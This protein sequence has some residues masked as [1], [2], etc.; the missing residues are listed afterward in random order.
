MYY[1]RWQAIDE[2][3]NRNSNI[4]DIAGPYETREDAHRGLTATLAGGRYGLCKL[5]IVEVDE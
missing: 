5:E 2:H 1:I 4:V 3:G